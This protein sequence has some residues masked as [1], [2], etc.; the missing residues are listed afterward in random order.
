MSKTK[1]PPPT[2]SKQDTIPLSDITITWT[3]RGY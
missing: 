2:E 3:Q 1:V